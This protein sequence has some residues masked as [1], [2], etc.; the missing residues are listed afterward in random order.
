MKSEHKWENNW[1]LNIRDGLLIDVVDINKFKSLDDRYI[2]TDICKKLKLNYKIGE[3]VIN[4]YYRSFVSSV[5]FVNNR[6]LS[7][8][9]FIDNKFFI[10]NDMLKF[11]S[12]INRISINKDLNISVEHFKNLILRISDNSIKACKQ[13]RENTTIYIS[14]IMN[15]NRELI[16]LLITLKNT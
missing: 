11:L 14:R 10:E 12:F 1:D 7:M 3:D 2:I 4:I 15:I 13:I 5:R 8:S 6:I 9:F 16:F